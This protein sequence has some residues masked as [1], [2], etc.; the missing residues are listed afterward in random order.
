VEAELELEWFGGLPERRFRKRR[1]DIE[2]L[3]WSTLRPTDHA[4][5]TVDRARIA[6][7]RNVLGEYTGAAQFAAISGALLA[8]RAPLDLIAMAGDALIDELSHVELA[9]RIAMGLGGA[10]P[11]RVD[12]AA[13]APRAD[14]AS[15]ARQR[16]SELAVR[17][18]CVTESYNLRSLIETSADIRHPLLRAANDLLVRD[19]AQHAQLGWLYLDWIGDALDDA[20]RARLAAAAED[21]MSVL[22]AAAGD[23]TAR[24]A[25]RRRLADHVVAP[26]ARHGI[27]TS[28]RW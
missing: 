18:S 5:E 4:P 16:A 27:L 23:E 17:L 15:T 12:L 11:T 19:E 7:T 13:L 9:A 21:Q 2:D 26:L 10:V 6:W 20:E 28:S 25:A 24:G 8:A 14:P 3:P 1:P 22:L